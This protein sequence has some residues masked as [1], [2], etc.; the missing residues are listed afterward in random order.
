MN[1]TEDEET[2]EDFEDD[3]VSDE[4]ITEDETYETDQKLG[5]CEECANLGVVRNV[6]NR[7]LCE[8]CADLIEDLPKE[9]T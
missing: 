4:E 2:E 8:A 3:S 7:I 1:K 5:V 9:E 6:K